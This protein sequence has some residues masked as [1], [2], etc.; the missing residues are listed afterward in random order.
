MIVFSYLHYLYY[1][2]IIYA[3][4]K[5]ARHPRTHPR[6]KPRLID[7]TPIFMHTG[8]TAADKV[9]G[10]NNNA[11]HHVAAFTNA[12]IFLHSIHPTHGINLNPIQRTHLASNAQ[13]DDLQFLFVDVD[14]TTT[15]AVLRRWCDFILR[16]GED[17][18]N[19]DF[20]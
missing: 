20:M 6:R 14:S 10:N 18:S 16:H 9:F 11:F 3:A 17:P 19:A 15:M 4:R 7:P 1:L 8:A 12:G 5:G 13:H 2:V